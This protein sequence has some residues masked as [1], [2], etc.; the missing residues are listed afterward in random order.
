MG[1]NLRVSPTVNLGLC[2]P[3]TWVGGRRSVLSERPLICSAFGGVAERS[4]AAVS[5]TVI[6]LNG[7]S[8]V[9]IPPPPLLKAVREGGLHR[10]GAFVGAALLKA[11]PQVLTFLHDYE[12]IVIGAIMMG[13][14]IFLREGI[15]PTIAIALASRRPSSERLT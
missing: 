8:R 12:P 7:G 2:R 13:V 6:R 10:C 3:N 11:L 14:M 1:E 9:Q 5:K 4:N 15:V